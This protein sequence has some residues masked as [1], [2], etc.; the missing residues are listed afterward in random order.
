MF[1]EQKTKVSPKVGEQYRIAGTANSIYEISREAGNEGRDFVL[2]NVNSGWE[3][4][5]HNVVCWSN[6]T[7]EWDYSSDGH[8]TPNCPGVK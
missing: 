3:C 7:I 8:F 2:T 4:L 6:G 1:I 5:A